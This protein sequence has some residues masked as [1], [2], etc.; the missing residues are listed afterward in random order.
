[1]RTPLLGL[2]L[3]FLTGYVTSAAVLQ[4]VGTRSPGSPGSQMEFFTA[5][6]LL[7]LSLLALLVA[8]SQWPSRSGVF[9][10]LSGSAV[11]AAL[12]LDERLELHERAGQG[13]MGNDDSIKVLLW[14]CTA[15]V[16]AVIARRYARRSPAVARVLAVGYVL[17]GL[18]LS[19]DVGDGDLFRVPLPF[20]LAAIKAAEEYLELAFLSV[21]LVGIVLVY[22]GQ[23]ASRH[24]NGARA[25]AGS[26]REDGAQ[27][28]RGRETGCPS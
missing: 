2:L 13:V 5:C 22:A 4:A 23:I 25:T 27:L 9:L 28:R 17:H 15:V 12:G 14:L 26:D 6:L 11:L 1:M 16:L 18:Y 3:L 20:S 19:L 8:E 10:W 21:Y 7:M 24:E